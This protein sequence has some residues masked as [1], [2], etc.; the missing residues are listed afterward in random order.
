MTKT[1]QT[2]QLPSKLNRR[3][4]QLMM[5]A[6]LFLVFF[7]GGC[8]RNKVYEANQ[9]LPK[10]IWEADNELT[11]S[12]SIEDTEQL[13]NLLVNIRHSGMLYEYS[14]I[15][16]RVKIFDPEKKE[17]VNERFQ[18]TLAEKSGK[19][20]GDCSGDICDRQATFRQEYKFKQEG[21][22]T[23]NLQQIMR[24]EALPAVMSAGFRIEKAELKA[25]EE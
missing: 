19:W 25:K 13:Y 7:W 4:H 10:Y 22:Y 17:L 23:I 18:I 1:N 2:K 3:A 9:D 24:D 8:D 16:L 15:W 12:A 11:F 21:D 20:L 14:N 5:L 6:V